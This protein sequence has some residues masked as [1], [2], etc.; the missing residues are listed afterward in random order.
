VFILQKVNTRQQTIF[1]LDWALA[2]LAIG[3]TP[4]QQ[5]IFLLGQIFLNPN[6]LWDG[7]FATK[8]IKE[9][10]LITYW[11]FNLYS[12]LHVSYCKIPCILHIV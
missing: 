5:T 2:G 1:F 12:D 4:R 10:A 3:L 9:L 6:Q 11:H 8:K 7:F